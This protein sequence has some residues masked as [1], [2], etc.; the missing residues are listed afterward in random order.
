MRRETW[1]RERPV[2]SMQGSTTRRPSEARPRRAPSASTLR[3][4]PSANA[5]SSFCATTLTSTTARLRKSSGSAAELCRRRSTR[6]TAHCEDCLMRRCLDDGL[7]PD[8]RPRTR[9]ACC[10]R[11]VQPGRHPA[12]GGRRCGKLEKRRAAGFEE[13]PCSLSCSW[14]FLRAVP[15]LLHAS[16]CCRGLTKAAGRPPASRSTRHGRIVGR[17]RKS[18]CV[19]RLGAARSPARLVPFPRLAAAATSSPSG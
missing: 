12:S 7:R 11:R 8:G 2:S 1:L 16:I 15:W 19:R 6:R 17:H 18:S 10:R 13:A 14:R 3:A 5:S 9:P 4:C